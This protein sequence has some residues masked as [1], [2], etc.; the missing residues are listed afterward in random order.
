M[1]TVSVRISKSFHL[2]ITNHFIQ[3]CE[4]C[5]PSL[6]RTL[7]TRS[8][9]G[10]VTCLISKWF[11]CKIKKKKLFHKIMFCNTFATAEDAQSGVQFYFSQQLLL[12]ERLQDIFISEGVMLNNILR[13]SIQNWRHSNCAIKLNSYGHWNQLLSHHNLYKDIGVCRV[14]SRCLSCHSCR[15]HTPNQSLQVHYLHPAKDNWSLSKIF[16]QQYNV[17]IYMD[18][19][20]SVHY[21]KSY[22]VI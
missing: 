10:T 7:L 19:M 21:K 14:G 12:P 2:I 6:K 5:F 18:K 4:L 9:Y 17:H 22:K 15:S 16:W 20:V 8:T 1:K 13:K 3:I 11:S